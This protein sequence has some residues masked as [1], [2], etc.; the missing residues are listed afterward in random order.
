MR[1][2]NQ[3]LGAKYS[4]GS[5]PSPAE[6]L[7]EIEAKFDEL[8]SMKEI[9]ERSSVDLDNIDQLVIN[10]QQLRLGS[11]P[12]PGESFCHQDGDSR[13]PV[14]HIVTSPS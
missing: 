13:V 3:Y 1:L 11:P 10:Y 4:A 12:L 8:T 5:D 2:L 7:K 14:A 6:A 9:Y